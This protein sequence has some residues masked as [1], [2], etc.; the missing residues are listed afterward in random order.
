T[1]FRLSGT[2][3]LISFTTFLGVGYDV[4]RASDVMG[5][6][7]SQ[8][9]TNLPGTGGIVQSTDTNAIGQARR[10]YLVRLSP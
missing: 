7:W 1:D 8:V 9:V 2:N 10:F 3:C 4:Q 6:A 5:S